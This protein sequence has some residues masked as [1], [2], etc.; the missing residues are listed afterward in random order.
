MEPPFRT[1]P[2]LTVFSHLRPQL[3]YNFPLDMVTSAG[4]PFWSGP[5]RAPA[6]LAFSADDPTHLGFVTAAAN[7]RAANYGL[8]A[9]RDEAAVRAALADVMVP[10]FTPQKGVKIQ[11]ALREDLARF[12]DSI[13]VA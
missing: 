9:C 1:P 12:E 3:L 6:P 2:P 13:G 7:L 4:T 10:E 11:V 8:P 5:K